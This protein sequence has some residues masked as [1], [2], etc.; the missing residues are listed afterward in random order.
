M[1][2]KIYMGLWVRKGEVCC[3]VFRGWA[4]K[5]KEIA[6]LHKVKG[7]Q[8]WSSGSSGGK[9]L[10]GLGWWEEDKIWKKKGMLRKHDSRCQSGE[11]D[12]QWE[13]PHGREREGTWG[14]WYLIPIVIPCYPRGS[15]WFQELPR[16]PKPGDAQVPYRKCGVGV[17]IVAQR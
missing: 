1:L 13:G 8:P 11:G 15:N 2:K 3:L 9:W 5:E 10:Y 4:V 14:L 7:R 6:L 16:I 12:S 17:P